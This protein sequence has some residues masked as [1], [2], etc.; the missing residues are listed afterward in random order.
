VDEQSLSE[1]LV[2]CDFGCINAFSDKYVFHLKNYF[3]VGGMPEAVASF[4][5][6]NDYQEV[7]RIQ[8]DILTQY[9]GDFSKHIASKD[10]PRINMVW[11]S[12]PIQLAKENKK[13]FFGK[14]KKGS[15]SKDY[16]TA[17]Q[18]LV[19]CGLVYKVHCVNE[20][21]VPLSAYKDFSA[22]KLFMIDVGLLGAM[23]D[24][25]AKSLLDGNDLFIEFK[26][27][28]TE[29]YVLQELISSTEYTPYYYGTNTARYEQD[30]MIQQGMDVV[31]IEVK[32][33]KNV[34][35]QSLKAFYDKYHPKKS[36]R[37]SLQ[38]YKEQGWMTNIPLYA[39]CTECEEMSLK[40]AK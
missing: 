3:Y 35:S 38:K 32:A 15:R 9:K 14:M 13:F 2:S 29:Q 34:Y 24:L 39:V 23:S 12:V 28:L 6:E 26:G 17:I 27:A 33:G 19:D 40:S 4:R 22:Y 5:M 31:P 8:K 10:I 25:D 37:F 30:F 36:I 18:W 20:P 11:E 7:R 1:T 21:H 16:E